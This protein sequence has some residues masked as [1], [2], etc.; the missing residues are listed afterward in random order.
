MNK[1]LLDELLETKR[2]AL[3]TIATTQFKEYMDFIGMPYMDFVCE[4]LLYKDM[5][6][7][8]WHAQI[9][10][11][12]PRGVNK[13]VEI[14][15]AGIWNFDGAV[16]DIEFRKIYAVQIGVTAHPRAPLFNWILMQENYL[17]TGDSEH[18]NIFEILLRGCIGS[19]YIGGTAKG[20]ML[21]AFLEKSHLFY[22]IDK[23]IEIV[24]NKKVKRH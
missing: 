4:V 19:L 6:Q 12:D 22:N 13:P 17:R 18:D 9:I 7:L 1:N 8:R 11:Y 16:T 23:A 15:A 3:E 2:K 10:I 21:D 5:F 20:D 14:P 24:K